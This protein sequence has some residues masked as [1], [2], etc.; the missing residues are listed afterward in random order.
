MRHT[1]LCKIWTFHLPFPSYIQSSRCDLSI[2][3]RSNQLGISSTVPFPFFNMSNIQCSE[4]TWWHSTNVGTISTLLN[5]LNGCVFDYLSAPNA[6]L[7]SFLLEENWK[8]RVILP[9][10][11]FVEKNKICQMAITELANL[12]LKMHLNRK[13]SYLYTQCSVF[14]SNSIFVL[15]CVHSIFSLLLQITSEVWWNTMTPFQKEKTDF[16]EGT[17]QY[18]SMY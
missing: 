8:S 12:Y 18:C 15:S 13:K 6:F 11:F 3:I 5:W 9:E 7:P 16:S 14:S 2:E 1:K 17:A 4:A 10:S